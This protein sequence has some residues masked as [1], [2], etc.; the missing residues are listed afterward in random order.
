M[1]EAFL[2]IPPHF[3][4]WLKTFNVKPKV[5][6]GEHAECGD[7]MISKLPNATWPKGSFVETNKVWQQ[8]WLYITEPRDTNW[9]AEPAFRSGPP[10]RLTSWTKKGLDWGSHT[11]VMTLLSRVSGVISKG[12]CSPP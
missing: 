5:V 12:T 8:E 10:E 1:C 11:E 9:V 6:D 3:G 4:L 2:R 7:A